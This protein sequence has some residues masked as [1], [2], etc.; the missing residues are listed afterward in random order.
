[1]LNTTYQGEIRFDKPLCQYYY[2][3]TVWPGFTSM[4]V[5]LV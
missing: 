2:Y 3:L 4:I 1:M 5:N